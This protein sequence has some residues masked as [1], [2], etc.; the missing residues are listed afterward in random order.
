[1]TFH[2][3]S[4]IDRLYVPRSKCG[5]GMIECKNCVITEENSLGWYVKNH[6]EQL[7]TAVRNSN[8][9]P[10]CEESMKPEELRNLKQNESIIAWKNKAMHGQYLKEMD[11]KDI[12]NTCCWQQESDLKGCTEAL[13]CSAQEPAH[14]IKFRIDKTIDSPLC[15]M[16]GNKNKTVSHIVSEWCMLAQRENKRSTTMLQGMCIGVSVK[17]INSTEPTNGTITS[18]RESFR[19]L[20]TRFYGI[21]R[22]SATK[23]FVLVDKKPD[24]VL[25]DKK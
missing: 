13:I 22:F 14:Y 2:L 17:N 24:I 11:G 6:V 1:M 19:M 21:P 5:R 25:V 8:T 12:V 18:Q 23:R 10:N 20:I 9:I 16:C 7:F 3:K 4:D 15:R